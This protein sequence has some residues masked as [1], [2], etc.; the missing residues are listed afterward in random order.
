MSEPSIPPVIDPYKIL[1]HLGW[2]VECES[3]FEIR[4]SDGSFATLNAA[5]I[6]QLVVVRE[7]LQSLTPTDLQTFI[8]SIPPDKEG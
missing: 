7:Y 1:E 4:H 5:R 2:I 8:G 6:V 3:P